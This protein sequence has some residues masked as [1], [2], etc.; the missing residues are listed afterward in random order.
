MV[1]LLRPAAEDQKRL[2]AEVAR[3]NAEHSE[4]SNTVFLASAAVFLR[5]LCG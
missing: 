2:T 5:R 3:E 4:K 1:N